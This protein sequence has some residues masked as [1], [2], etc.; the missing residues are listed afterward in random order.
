MVD[1]KNNYGVLRGNVLHFYAIRGIIMQYM[2][3]KDDEV[4]QNI[5]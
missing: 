4:W 3:L 2:I 5:E 1:I